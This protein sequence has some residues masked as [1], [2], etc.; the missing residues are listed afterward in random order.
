MWGCGLR[1]SIR[2]HGPC[3]L[4]ARYHASLYH[5]GDGGDDGDDDAEEREE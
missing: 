1:L 5:D 3:G 4:S 2:Y